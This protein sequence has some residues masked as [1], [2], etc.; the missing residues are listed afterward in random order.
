M[1]RKNVVVYSLFPETAPDKVEVWQQG[2]VGQKIKKMRDRSK[3]K[4]CE[5]CL[6]WHQDDEENG[7]CEIMEIITDAVQ[8]GCIDWRSK[9]TG[10]Q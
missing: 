1:K 7:T 2:G 10:K 6:F 8:S 9:E 4:R 3:Y 5:N